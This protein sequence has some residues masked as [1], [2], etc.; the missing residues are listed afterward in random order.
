YNGT[1]TNYTW[2]SSAG[3]YTF[4]GNVTFTGSPSTTGTYT[5]D[6]SVNNP[7]FIFNGN[8]TF[9][10]GT[11]TLNWTKGTG[12]ITFSGTTAQTADFLGKT[13]EDINITNTSADVSITNDVVCDSLSVS[14]GASVVVTSTKEITTADIS[15]LGG[16]SA[17]G[18][19]TMSASTPS[20]AFLLTV[21]GTPVVYFINVTDCD[22]SGG[23][24]IT[25]Y[26]SVNGTGNTNWVFAGSLRGLISEGI[27]PYVG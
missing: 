20:S 6:N 11:S 21:S 22:A 9:S 14:N 15:G 26:G 17:T 16:D 10:N 12:T 7:N 2:T 25:A 24:E 5:I 3:T 1:T 18:V 8:V 13:V 27:I 23:S 19:V 4:N